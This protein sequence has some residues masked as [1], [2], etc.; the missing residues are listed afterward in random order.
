M[1]F[2]AILFICA[3][4]SKEILIYNEEIIVACCF[5]DF[6]IYT[7]KNLSKTKTTYK[8]FINQ[9]IHIHHNVNG[10]KDTNFLFATLKQSPYI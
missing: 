6:I 5:I 2:A 9:I 10:C 1:L 4:N 7:R 8:L 3:L